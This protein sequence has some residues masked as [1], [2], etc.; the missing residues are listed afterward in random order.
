M[1]TEAE[2]IHLSPPDTGSVDVAAVV[3]AM[4][5]GWVAPAGPDLAAFEREVAAVAGRAHAAATSSG[6][7]ALHLA[8]RLVGVGADSDVLMPTLTFV[9]SANAAVYL[10]ARP[11]FL[12]VDAESWTIDCQMLADELAERAAAGRLP[13][14]VVAVDL[15]GQCAD[16]DMLT[17][18][19]K[20][21]EVP[22]VLDSAEALGARFHDRPAGQAGDLA[23]FSFNGNKIITTGGGG[24]LV[25][26]NL[27]V[28]ERARSLA[29]QARLPVVHYEHHELGYNY[30]LSNLLAALGRAQLRSLPQRVARR[31]AINDTYREALARLPGVDFQ[32]RLPHAPSTHWLT[33]MTLDAEAAARPVDVIRH[34]DRHNVEV[35]P[36]WMPMH[37]Q[38]LFHGSPRRGGTE[39][40]RLFATSVCLPSGSS[41]SPVQQDRVITL[42]LEIL[43]RP[44]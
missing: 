43:D 44:A 8:L 4:E 7:A 24:M 25:G 28:I 38:P 27:E 34:M 41:L 2:R 33:V 35:R 10:G 37:L 23:I 16:Y 3:A 26:D 22:L 36:G 42:L 18:V 9:A 32:P 19:C 12:D 17:S 40:E 1:T 29:S 14:A 39:A 30:R 15:Y 5:A 6:T 13:S 20:E 11:V 21:F 31:V